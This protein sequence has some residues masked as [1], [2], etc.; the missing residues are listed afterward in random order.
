[1]DR[2]W[3]LD[4][5]ALLAE[6]RVEAGGVAEREL[7]A[8]VLGE[9]VGRVAWT[10][11]DWALCLLRCAQCGAELGTGARECVS[12][13]M[14]SDNRWAW[15]HQCPPSAITANEHNLRVAREALRAPHRHRATIVAGWRLVMPFLLAGAVVTNGQAQRI[16]AHVL[17]ERYDE[18]AGCRSYT[19][20]AGLPELPWRQPS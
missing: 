2:Y 11:V 20:L 5:Q 14:A 19:E 7:A 1:M 3:L 10:C 9:P 17:A 4:W 15:H 12:C 16:R 13:T 18:L 6:R 8:R